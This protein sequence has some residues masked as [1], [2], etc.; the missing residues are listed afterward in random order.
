MK[1][2]R[3]KYDLLITFTL[4]GTW[5]FNQITDEE[6]P[7]IRILLENRIHLFVLPAQWIIAK[8]GLIEILSEILNLKDLGLIH[9]MDSANQEIAV[10]R[11]GQITTPGTILSDLVSILKEKL[12]IPY[13]QYL[14]E[15]NNSISRISIII[16][17]NVNPQL[18]KMVKRLKIDTII[19]TNFSLNTEKIAEDFDINLIAV[20]EY[21][22]NLGL[23]K[24][25][26]LLRM[27]HYDIEFAFEN[28]KPSFK[29]A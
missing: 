26:Q 8:S 10:G 12:N 15:E 25:T 20:T 2:V 22:A 13:L 16:G 3:D 24:L 17:H 14:G 11:V 18:L 7:K 28:I 27:E 29:I 1:A 9:I 21:I 4:P 23:L 5:N 6:Y 19:C